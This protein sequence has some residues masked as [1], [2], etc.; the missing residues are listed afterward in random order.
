MNKFIPA[1][2]II[3]LSCSQNKEAGKMNKISENN[4]I[5]KEDIIKIA[6]KKIYFGH[7]SVGYNI[8]EGLTA[9][10]STDSG[11][12]IVE[13]SDQ[14]AFSRPLFA[15]SKN[16]ENFK[17]ETKIKAFIKKMDSGLGNKVDIAFFKFCY[18]DITAGTDVNKLFSD[19]KKAMD[20]LIKKYPNTRFLHI[21]A[22]VTM[23]DQ[24]IKRRIKDI[25][26]GIIG[27]PVESQHAD[28]IQRMNYNTLLKNE[29]G[30]SVFD[31]AEAESTDITGNVLFSSKGK[32]PHYTLLKE[33][34]LDGGH[35]NQAGGEP[36]AYQFIN[37]IKQQV[38]K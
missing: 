16:G 28:N 7:Q 22:P 31:L 38:E 19:Y 6:S 12:N 35:L 9:L 15:H 20:T 1:L 8:I 2:L 17:P 4:K 32:T 10:L 13:T 36:V 33:Y 29:Y 23:E 30:S 21:T 26:K 27:R 11:I 5:N 37:F 3:L 34:T 14:N 24:S 25:I 18:V